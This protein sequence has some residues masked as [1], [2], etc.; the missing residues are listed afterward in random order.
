MARLTKAQRA[1]IVDNVR[2]AAREN[3]RETEG[4]PFDKETRTYGEGIQEAYAASVRSIGESLQ[5]QREY[6]TYYAPRVLTY[7]ESQ[8]IVS[9]LLNYGY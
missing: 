3:A 4:I 8:S 1:V 6:E 5:S 2:M 9:E 7:V